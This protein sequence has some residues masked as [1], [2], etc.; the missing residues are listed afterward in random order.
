MLQRYAAL[1]AELTA[2]IDSGVLPA[3]DQALHKRGLE[4]VGRV[5]EERRRELQ[6]RP[7]AE[8]GESG[9]KK[10]GGFAF[11]RK[12][13]ASAPAPIAQSATETN[14]ETRG[15]SSN[16]PIGVTE[17]NSSATNHLPISSLKNTTYTA[18]SDGSEESLSVSISDICNSLIDL[19]PFH[20][21]HTIRSVQIRS[22]HSSILLLPPVEGSVM[23]HDLSSSVLTVPTCHQFRMHTSKDVVVELSTKRGSVVTLEGCTRV[24]F[25]VREGE[26][27]KVQDFDDLINSAQLK[28]GETEGKGNFRIIQVS[29]KGGFSERVEEMIHEGVPTREILSKVF[30]EMDVA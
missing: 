26:G 12:P 11:R 7:G 29:E 9:R 28:S 27:I 2:A 30:K 20:P 25:R 24:R 3:H 13:P 17:P 15:E 5:L 4:E 1:S 8:N 19:R 18:S 6:A 14:A 22:V 10:G 23:I 16:Q 21:S